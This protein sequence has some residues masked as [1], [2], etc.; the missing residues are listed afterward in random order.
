VAGRLEMSRG[1]QMRTTVQ[2]AEHMQEAEPG[3][4]WLL[5]ACTLVVAVHNVSTL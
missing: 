1:E 5:G 3:S 2:W 4:S